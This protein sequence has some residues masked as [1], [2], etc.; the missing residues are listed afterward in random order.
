MPSNRAI[1]R[2]GRPL[3]HP[4]GSL[5][6]INIKKMAHFRPFLSK[7]DPIE[8]DSRSRIQ[9]RLAFE[10]FFEQLLIDSHSEP[11]H[12]SLSPIISLVFL[13]KSCIVW[14]ADEGCLSFYSPELDVIINDKFSL[15]FAVSSS[16]TPLICSAYN[17]VA[18][19]GLL[20]SDPS[21]PQMLIPLYS[22]EGRII[23]V[24]QLIR[25]LSQPHF[26][27]EDMQFATYFMI[28]F[29]KYYSSFCRGGYFTKIAYTFCTIGGFDSLF[30]SFAPNLNNLFPGSIPEFWI[31]NNGQISLLNKETLI[32]LNRK[33]LGIVGHS[34]ESME[35]VNIESSHFHQHYSITIDKEPDF[36]ILSVPIKTV[37]GS[38]CVALRRK[39]LQYTQA[40]VYKLVEITPFIAKSF[41]FSFH[42]DSCGNDDEH[43]K[44]K[45][46]QM[47]K[48]FDN[49]MSSDDEITSLIAKESRQLFARKSRSSLSK[50][51]DSSSLK[52][53]S[54]YSDNNAGDD[55]SFSQSWNLLCLNRIQ[56]DE[57]KNKLS[58]F[59]SVLSSLSDSEGILNS[60]VQIIQNELSPKSLSVFLSNSIN[61]DCIPA[62]MYNCTLS[63]VF[64]EINEC[65]TRGGLIIK[66][67]NGQEIKNRRAWS[68]KN[69]QIDQLSIEYSI[70]CPFGEFGVIYVCFAECYS[71]SNVFY[72][73]SLILVLCQFL[74]TTK[75]N[76][77]SMGDENHIIQHCINAT[78]ISKYS[79]PE[80]LQHNF[81]MSIDLDISS[82]DEIQLYGVCFHTFDRFKIL[83]DLQ[84]TSESLLRLL[85]QIYV[86]YQQ[87]NP[88]GFICSVSRMIVV[89]KLIIDGEMQDI[90]SKSQIFW[91]L[92]AALCLHLSFGTT[93]QPINNRASEMMNALLRYQSL[94]EGKSSQI[95]I[96]ILNRNRV[97]ENELVKTETEEIVPNLM[98]AASTRRHASFIKKIEET[99]GEISTMDMMILILKCAEHNAV[100][101]NISIEERVLEQSEKFFL[102]AD[103][104]KIPGIF[105]KSSKSRST[106]DIQKS[107]MSYL[108]TIVYPIYIV[109]S[110]AVP[111]LSSLKN[112][113]SEN[114]KLIQRIA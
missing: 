56:F 23:Y 69:T 26:T 85:K 48:S 1:S 6:S 100:I 40:D 24:I 91:M 61:N 111:K 13:T 15:L 86:I 45:L 65:K 83:Q 7:L 25:H 49:I 46:I 109:L 99:S 76:L 87:N 22:I 9:D 62:I 39:R 106:I 55:S 18:P 97:F 98:I 17:P 108:S 34:L 58:K 8:V 110:K 75:Y 27:D 74:K 84:I 42:Q 21:S 4:E 93:E 82:F 80:K 95:L 60:I 38:L 31:M 36:S 30:R 37:F 63:D 90:F 104:D 29:S 57:L 77:K 73:K 33:Q 51:T 78:E 101:S 68:D 12:I 71:P 53:I 3:R 44:L 96:D 14:V 11:F 105:Y 19:I 67:K 41:E 113:A 16:K 89:Y 79:I 5:S 92:L 50:F 102:T 114:I 59:T 52:S 28:K 81:D 32:Q 2:Q 112:K 64:L 107:I 66:P 20:V 35:I 47:I 88:K 70:A 54:S 43:L 103:I 94:Y 10:H 72:Q